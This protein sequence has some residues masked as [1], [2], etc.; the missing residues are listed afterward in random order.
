M[1][2]GRPEQDPQLR[3]EAD[4]LLDQ[5]K[6]SPISPAAF[7]DLDPLEGPPPSLLDQRYRLERLIGRGGFGIVYFARDER[8]HDKP[9]VVK[10]LIGERRDEWFRKKFRD[11]IE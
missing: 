6:T 4:T 5:T 8:L 2:P 10:F 1:H 11:E 3:K 7:L 9:V